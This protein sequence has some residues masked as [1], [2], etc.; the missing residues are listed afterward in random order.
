ML[1][2]LPKIYHHLTSSHDDNEVPSEMLFI[3]RFTKFGPFMIRVESGD[4]GTTTC[5]S[6]IGFRKHSVSSR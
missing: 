6:L 5:N 3:P 4:G 2:P 1:Y